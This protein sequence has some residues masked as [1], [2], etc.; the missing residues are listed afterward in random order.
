MEE[1]KEVVKPFDWLE[2]NKIIKMKAHLVWEFCTVHN[3]PY[4]PNNENDL[5]GGHFNGEFD[6]KM[7]EYGLV[8]LGVNWC[9]GHASMVLVRCGE[10][11]NAIDQLILTKS[12][13]IK[14]FYNRGKCNYINPQLKSYN[15]QV[16]SYTEFYEIILLELE[17]SSFVSTGFLN[18][19]VDA[20]D[21]ML[22][23]YESKIK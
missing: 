15:N 7:M 9:F 11:E 16:G 14:E 17:Y 3:I 21:L 5:D 12:E 10:I 8:R 18:I 20:L 6:I 2:K 23:Y 22:D 4:V 1:I 19:Y 13:V